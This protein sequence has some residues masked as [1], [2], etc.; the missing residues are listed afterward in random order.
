MPKKLDFMTSTTLKVLEFFSADARV[1]V[2]EREVI[3]NTKN[4]LELRCS[5]RV[6]NPNS[7]SAI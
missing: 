2:H 4:Q 6:R 5:S 7:L 3:E 1:E